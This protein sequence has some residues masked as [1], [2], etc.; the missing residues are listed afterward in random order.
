METIFFPA[1]VYSV[2]LII[3]KYIFSRFGDIQ[4]MKV[5]NLK[6]AFTVLAIVVISGDF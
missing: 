5:E 1:Y 4:N 6:Q 3:H 2:T